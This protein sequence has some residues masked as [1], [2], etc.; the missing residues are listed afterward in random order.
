M[1][2][3]QSLTGLPLASPD[4]DLFGKRGE[5]ERERRKEWEM[6]DGGGREEVIYLGT[7]LQSCYWKNLTKI[8]L[9]VEHVGVQ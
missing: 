6:G 7:T 8:H 4:L 2:K 9:P 5:V 3:V 1:Q